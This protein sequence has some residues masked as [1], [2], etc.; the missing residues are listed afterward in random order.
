VIRTLSSRIVYENPWVSVREDEIE[1][2]DGS[3]GIHA[4]VDKHDGA[5]IVPWDGERTTIVG[6]VKYPIG[7]FCWEFPQG[8]SDHDASATAEQ[9]ARAELAEETGLQAG[10]LTRLGRL[11]YAPGIMNQAFDAWFATDLVAGEARPEATEVGMRS[12]A[13]TPAEL[14]ELVLAGDFVD[15][16]S[17]AVLH[18]LRI[19]GVGPW[20]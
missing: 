1:R 12:R 17:L 3:H 2:E 15:S 10:T 19:R 9:T 8:A 16:A 18:L 7:R 13:V 20:A 4:A 6:Q 5:V 14:D 11:H